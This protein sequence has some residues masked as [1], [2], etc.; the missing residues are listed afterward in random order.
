MDD[1][2]NLGNNNKHNIGLEKKGREERN[3]SLGFCSDLRN[4]KVIWACFYF[5]VLPRVTAVLHGLLKYET[6]IKS[7]FLRLAIMAGQVLY[8]NSQCF[9]G[10]ENKD[11][12]VESNID[13]LEKFE[14]CM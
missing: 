1:L 11:R 8:F 5:T 3:M 13:T 6:S 9:G 7:G 14:V 2:L 10:N 12:R 4:V